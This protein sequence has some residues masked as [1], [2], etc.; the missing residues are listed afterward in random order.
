MMQRILNILRGKGN[1][2]V[3]VNGQTYVGDNISIINDRVFVDGVEQEQSFANSNHLIEVTVTGDVAKIETVSGNIRVTGTA[4]S[5]ST[6]SGDAEVG[7]V[8]GS[9]SSV[10]GDVFVKGNVNGSISTV[11]GDVSS[12]LK[13]PRGDIR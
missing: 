13:R 1:G 9:V 4:G 11:S 5:V 8:Q 3:S 6:T 7:H 12:S 2:V 10:S